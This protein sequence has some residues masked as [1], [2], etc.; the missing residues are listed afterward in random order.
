MDPRKWC[1][2]CILHFITVES[3]GPAGW[4]NS[5]RDCRNGSSSALQ[6][7]TPSARGVSHGLLDF[8]TGGNGRRAGVGRTAGRGDSGRT[9]AAGKAWCPREQTL[10]SCSERRS[11]AT[12]ARSRSR[13]PR[14]RFR[15]TLF[16][17]V[18]R[19]IVELRLSPAHQ[20]GRRRQSPR[21]QAS[22]CCSTVA[23]AASPIPIF[24]ATEPSA[25]VFSA[26]RAVE[27][28]RRKHGLRD[29]R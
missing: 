13:W 3:Q 5:A 15:R 11:S 24:I 17:E 16:A 1:V 27:T 8:C 6:R 18:T 4:K 29:V 9:T 22:L 7:A 10:L 21:V 26:L 19:M 25:K 28:I 12:C 23:P 20:P 14:S 2:P